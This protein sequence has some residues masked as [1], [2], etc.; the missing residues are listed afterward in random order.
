MKKILSIL[1]LFA[2]FPTLAS[3]KSNIK[4]TYSKS[5][6][7]KRL[8]DEQFRITQNDGTERAH[9]N[10]YWNNNE[11]GLYVDVV[12]GEPLFSSKDKFKS[13]TGWPS[14]TKP[15]V[16][17]HI[18]YKKDRSGFRTRTE[19]RSKFSDSHLGHVFDDGPKPTGKRYCINSAAL[20]F[21]PVKDLK[22]Q[23]YGEFVNEFKS[24]ATSKIAISKQVAYFAGGCFW[25]M[26]APFEKVSGVE[27]AISG[28]SGGIKKNPTYKEVSSGKTSHIESVKIVYDPTKV[29]YP[30]LLK[31]Y[32]RQIKPV[33]A[34]GQFHDH[35]PQYRSAIFY[36]NEQEKKQA[37]KS[38]ADLKALNLFDGKKIHTEIMAF[39]S[40][41]PAEEY[42]QDYYK[43]NPIR[44]KVYR[45]GSGRDAYLKKIW[46]K[47]KK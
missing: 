25:C 38:L 46:G 17:D 9:K 28:Y 24:D 18:V 44:Y 30:E 22:A 45:L 13:G 12:K 21:I 29:T 5:E 16:A 34:G 27:Q 3:W 2:F 33:Q 36:S 37:L 7:K 4:K 35:G 39:R 1:I 26:E 43:K 15:L 20:R 47:K 10:A 11:A 42:H 6:L 8:T 19:V 32:W 31:I 41:Y 14:F 23:G 40:F